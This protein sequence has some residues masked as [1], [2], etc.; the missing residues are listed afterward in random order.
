MLHGTHERAKEARHVGSRWT[1]RRAIWITV[2]ALAVATLVSVRVLD[3]S[4]ETSNAVPD[5]VVGKV[6]Q[7]GTRRAFSPDSW[8][9]TPIAADA[10]DNYAETQILD[11]LRTAP[12]SGGGCLRLAGAGG[13]PWGHPIYWARRSDPTYD[14]AGVRGD[15]P[16]ELDTLRIPRD[17]Q[18]ASNTDGTM[19][20]YDFRKGYVT[21]LT[22]AAYDPESD[23]WTAAG[24]TV[25]Y[26]K[27]NGLHVNT[28]Q[29]DDVRNRGT[30]RGNNGAT[31]TVSWDMVHTGAVRHVLKVAAG[32]EVANRFVF[33]MV[34]SD[35]DYQGDDPAVPPQGLRMRIRP[36]V[37]LEAMNL[38]PEA[39][40]IA[41]TLQ[42]YGFYIGD[43][44]GT[45]ALKL[46]D[47]EAEGRGQLWDVS[48]DDLCRLPFTPD[49][50]D[51]LPEGYAPTPSRGR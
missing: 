16:P 34:G 6:R 36:S 19:S 7:Q 31:S 27:S 9:N 23:S 39:L 28:G 12:E 37:D 2:F 3:R 26:L 10:P 47:T 32:P 49:F 48:Y 33:P 29:S 17:A 38:N 21:A 50:W 8:W 5:H 30:H 41:R 13:N 35:G 15:S 4:H 40:I 45:T 11:Y 14:V 51:V 24:A 44:G 1:S 22:D 46:E 20:I 18:P 43:S 25:T 42:R